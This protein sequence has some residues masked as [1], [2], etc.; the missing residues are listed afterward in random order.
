[1]ASS[2]LAYKATFSR[3][4]SCVIITMVA[5]VV[6]V[7]VVDSYQRAHQNTLESYPSFCM[8]LILGGE[9]PRPH[10]SSSV[11]QM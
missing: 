5:I 1:M 8:M 10:N 11:T 9:R 4:V 7:V 2:W 6:T 3:S